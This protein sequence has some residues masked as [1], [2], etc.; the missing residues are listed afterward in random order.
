MP[1]R[2][3]LETAVGRDPLTDECT[4]EGCEAA[5]VEDFFAAAEG[6]TLFILDSSGSMRGDAWW[7]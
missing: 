1:G 2:T 3:F 4:A 6:N 5:G 7:G